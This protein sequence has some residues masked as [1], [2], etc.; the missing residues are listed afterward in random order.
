[1]ELIRINNKKLK[2][3]LTPTDMSHF[4]L[5]ADMIGEDVGKTHHAFRLLLSELKNKIGFDAD[6]RHISI[7]YFPSREGGCEMFISNLQDHDEQENDPHT[8]KKQSSHALQVRP[9]KKETQYFWRDFVYRF[10]TLNDLLSVCKRLYTIG[11]I[12]ESSAYRD[13]KN[14]YYL[15]LSMRA[16]SPFSIPDEIGFVIEYGSIENVSAIKI[17][18]LEHG[19][20]ICQQNAIARLSQLF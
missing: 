3:M 14:D 5:T 7:Q 15:F 4:E 9:S 11:Y 6:D 16:A 13:E 20:P 8:E 18:I 17:Y 2:L 12:C 19:S 1:M 10:D